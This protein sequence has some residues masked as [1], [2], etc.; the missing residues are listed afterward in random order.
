MIP[1]LF[2]CRDA[3]LAVPKINAMRKYIDGKRYGIF[4]RFGENKKRQDSDEPQTK[5]QAIT[6]NQK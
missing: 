5:Y 4:A 2:F 3:E 1:I 6:G